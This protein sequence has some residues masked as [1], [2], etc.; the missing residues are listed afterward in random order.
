MIFCYV[1][2]LQA[3]FL[4]FLS[5]DMDYW[6]GM[7]DFAEEGVWIWQHS[8]QPVEYTNWVSGQPDDRDGHED[9]AIMV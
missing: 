2:F 8:Y 1:N 9:C 7:A 6:L 3:S 5:P 4:S